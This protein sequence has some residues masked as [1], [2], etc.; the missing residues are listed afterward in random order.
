MKTQTFTYTARSAVHPER[1]ITFTLHDHSLSLDLGAPLEQIERAIQA[2]EGEEGQDE[3]SRWLRPIALSM[4]QRGASPF[5]LDDVEAEVDGGGL[6]VTAWIR[7][8]G[9]RLA[10]LIMTWNQVDNPAGAEA[11]VREL[12]RRKQKAPEQ[13]SLGGPFDYWFSWLLGGL[14]GIVF[15]AVGLRSWLKKKE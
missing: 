9:L 11:F 4:L 2:Q 15:L 7:A 13:S 5:A 8:G 12:D 1:V 6:S 10:P 3:E 14:I